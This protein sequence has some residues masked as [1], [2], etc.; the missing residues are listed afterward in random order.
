MS[1]DK[2]RRCV[3]ST[4]AIV[5][6]CEMAR[7]INVQVSV[8]ST[9]TGG[10]GLPYIAMVHDSRRDTFRQF[11]Y[12][13]ST[14]SCTNTTPEGLCFEAIMK[15][16]IPTTNDTDSYFL[17]FSDG[18]PTYSIN[19]GGDE[20]HYG[21]DAAAEHTRK[22]VKKM[23]GNGI[24]ILSYF[25]TESRG[26]FEHTSDWQVFKKCY[27]NDAKYVN[28]ENMFEVAK[29]MNELFLKKS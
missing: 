24:N 15:E 6:A 25:I 17:N 22:Q 18:Q 4:V 11:C 13:M 19:R 27:G 29:S 8:R 21:G 20:I 2:L 26:N 12:F 23:Q 9:D 28:V 5:K 7:N 1:G 14:L 16:L 3:T 10:Q